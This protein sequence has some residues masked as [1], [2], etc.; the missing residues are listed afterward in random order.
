[1]IAPRRDWAPFALVGGPKRAQ[2]PRGI[3]TAEGLGD[4]LRTAAF[5]ELQAREG[6]LWA[7]ERFSD[8]PEEVRKAWRRL[9][10]E[11]GKHLGWLLRRM[12]ELGVD[13]ASRPVSPRLWDA[14]TACPSAREFAVLMALAEQRGKAAEESFRRALAQRDPRTSD[15][16]AKIAAE[17]VG[18][19]A[20]G[21]RCLTLLA[22]SR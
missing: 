18:H 10:A 14:L 15:I 1:M 3:S 16:F 21:E 17:E 6:F 13:P 22:A 4:R 11:E 8:A 12:G 7:A 9:S 2:T 19:L 5:A 20:V